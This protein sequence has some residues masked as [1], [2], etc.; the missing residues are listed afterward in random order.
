[1]KNIYLNKSL[2]VVFFIAF[3]CTES[4][5]PPVCV[6]PTAAPSGTPTFSSIKATSTIWG[7]YTQSATDNT[8]LTYVFVRASSTSADLPVN[9][10]NYTANTVFGSGTQ[11]GTSGW[12]CVYKGTPAAASV[13]V[14]GLSPGTTYYYKAYTCDNRSATYCY[15]TAAT[16]S[17]NVTTCSPPTSEPDGTPTFSGITGTT[18][19]WGTFSNDASANN[20]IV[21]CKENA[22]TADTP[23]NGT[24]YTASTNWSAKGT[25]IGATGW[26]CVYKGSASGASVAMTNLNAGGRYYFKAFSFNDCSSDPAF[27]T[28]A[29]LS[30]NEETSCSAPTNEPDGTPAFSG[31]TT[32]GMTWGT[33]TNDASANNTVIFC[34]LGSSTADNPVNGTT[35]TANTTFGSGTQI[36]ATGWYCVYNGSASGASVAVSGLSVLSTYFFKAYAYNSCSGN[37]KYY[38]T[39]TLSGN[40]TTLDGPDATYVFDHDG[41][42]NEYW[43]TKNGVE[44]TK[45]TTGDNTYFMSNPGDIANVG[46]ANEVS[47]SMG[48][49]ATPY[50][51]GSLQ[52]QSAGG[53][54][55]ESAAEGPFR[56]GTANQY[57]QI[58]ASGTDVLSAVDITV[59]YNTSTGTADIGWA[60][61]DESLTLLTSGTKTING[62]NQ[63]CSHFTETPPADAKYLRLIRN[64]ASFRVYAAEIWTESGC[65][66]EVTTWDGDTDANWN[67]AANWSNGIPCCTWKAIIPD[68]TTV[69][70]YPTISTTGCCDTIVFQAGAGVLGLEN[71]TY[72][73]AFIQLKTS[74]SHWYTLTPP[75]KQMYSGDYYLNNRPQTYMRLF[76]TTSPDVIG[77]DITYEGIFTRSFNTLDVP[78][79]SVEGFVLKVSPKTCVYPSGCTNIATDT[80]ITFP[81]TNLDGTLVSSYVPQSAYNYKP[82]T[83]ITNTVSKDALAYRFASENGSSLLVDVSY[84]LPTGLSLVGN[85]IMTHLNISDFL[86]TNSTDNGIISN[87]IKLWTGTSYETYDGVSDNWD[88]TYTGDLIAPMQSFIVNSGAGG[89]ILFDLD[90]HF[91]V[92]DNNSQ[93]RS[94]K[95]E[96]ENMLIIKA[97]KDGKTT[98]TVLTKYTAAK[99]TYDS[100]DIFKLFTPLTEVADVYSLSEGYALAFNKFNSYPFTAPLGIKTTEKGKVTLDFSGAESFKGADVYLIN[101]ETGTEQNIRENPTYNLTLNGTNQEGL[102]FISFRKATI[103]TGIE[104]AS[105]NESIQ[106][107]ASEETKIK[108][109]SAANDLIREI[110]VFSLSGKIIEQHCCFLN[111]SNFEIQAQK[112]QVYLVQVF[113][114][115]N[116]RIAKVFVK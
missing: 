104:N 98:G 42:T 51:S 69:T 88:G 60:Y 40:E 10:V 90:V 17:G 99:N 62:Y 61:Y 55:V 2:L 116:S 1:M 45:T 105:K 41:G 94:A 9:D 28:S 50:P 12:Y 18:L 6:T 63:A 53:C 16:L 97:T 31:I 57:F 21:F 103:S 56:L 32:N 74:R 36:G 101:S 33:F 8:S 4:Y 38:T 70:N 15:Y 109:E 64:S 93:L 49:V 48:G 20:T 54:A 86:N 39:A 73:K 30:G 77:P 79:A 84:T 114:D 113:T 5:A 75:L 76:D 35:Y 29:V 111:S 72:N 81:R 108:I 59:N 85:P 110:I 68:V 106:I 11:I 7:T 107:Y 34:K 14:T 95:A 91:A 71:L 46:Q 96:K 22:T 47:F 100:Q 115:N 26:Y 102:L 92:D 23:V 112:N 65:T 67:N 3:F 89:N 78:L 37:P 19:T 44:N 82:Y 80:T 43:Q 24:S 83:F 27:Y 52:S 58:E 25:Q 87:Y 13:T 66:W